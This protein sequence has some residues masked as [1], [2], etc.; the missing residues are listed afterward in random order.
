MMGVLQSDR[1]LAEQNFVEQG[2]SEV[3]TGTTQET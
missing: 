1:F 3:S 2:G